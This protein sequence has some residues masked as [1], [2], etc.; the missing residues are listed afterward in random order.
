MTE[1]S[2]SNEPSPPTGARKGTRHPIFGAL[3][4]MIFVPPRVD[5]TEPTDPEWGK[6]YDE[7]LVPD[8]RA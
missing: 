7:N 5:L 2:P 1:K 4:G 3:K 8:K 6:V